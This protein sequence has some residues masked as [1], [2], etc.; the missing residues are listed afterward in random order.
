MDCN[1]KIYSCCQFIAN[2]LGP[3]DLGFAAQSAVILLG[4]ITVGCA[5]AAG[6]ERSDAEGAH[7]ALCAAQ[8]LTP[9]HGRTALTEREAAAEYAA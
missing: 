3:S 6:R 1:L 9:L 2:S 8:D 7:S 5:P 4:C